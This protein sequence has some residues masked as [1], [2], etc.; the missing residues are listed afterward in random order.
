MGKKYP[1][2]LYSCSSGCGLSV[3]GT[4]ATVD[5]KKALG[6]FENA[7]IINHCDLMLHH[8]LTSIQVLAIAHLLQKLLTKHCDK[9]AMIATI[10]SK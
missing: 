4:I 10:T 7:Q 1:A 6:K 2:I 5:A 9:S 8:N 3:A